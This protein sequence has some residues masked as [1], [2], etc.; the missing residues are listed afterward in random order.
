V[1]QRPKKETH[2]ASLARTA[3]PTQTEYTT[4]Q[5]EMPVPKRFIGIDLHKFY[6]IAL[7]LDADLNQTLPHQRVQLSDLQTW[8]SKTLTPQDAVV[9]EMITYLNQSKLP[10]PV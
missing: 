5:T 4:M 3:R 8:I 1:K 6:L 7:G 2:P 10:H 9:L